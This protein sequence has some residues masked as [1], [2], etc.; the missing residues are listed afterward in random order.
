[1]S[2]DPLQGVV[3]ALGSDHAGFALKQ[4]VL[5]HLEERGAVTMDLGTHSEEPTDYPL[6]C[7]P[8][9]EAVATGAARFG[10]VLGGSG[11]G[12]QI[13]ANKVKGI[14]AALCYNELSASL[15]RRHNDANVLSLG[16]RLLGTELAL[17]IVDAFFAA[18]FEGGRHVRRLAQIA[19]VEEGISFVG[20]P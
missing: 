13:V 9:A 2:A 4:I 5:T 15:A 17:A 12:E 7:Q 11:Q 14:R 19:E 10:I 16:A 18:S 8:V 3:I 20:G 1:V 6:Y